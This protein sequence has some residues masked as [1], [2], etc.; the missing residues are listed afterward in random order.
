MLFSQDSMDGD[1][2]SPQPLE[3]VLDDERE[4]QREALRHSADSIARIL[5]SVVQIP[6]TSIHVGLDALLGL[7]P[8][9]GDWIANIIG[10][11]IL[12]LAVKLDVPKIVIVRMALNMGI[13]TTIGAIPGIGDL[14]SIWFRSNLKNAQLLRRY[15]SKRTTRATSGDWLFVIGLLIGTFA[16]AGGA[17]VLLLLGLQRIWSTG[18]HFL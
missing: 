10:S 1:P 15:T 3:P 5:D 14:F 2:A 7:I 13:N 17:F 4:R 8:G 6:G 12:F 18:N 9:L 11:T 16:I